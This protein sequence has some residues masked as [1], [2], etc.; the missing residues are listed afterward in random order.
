MMKRVAAG[1]VDGLNRGIG[2]PAT[3]VLNILSGVEQHIGDSRNGNREP[4][5]IPALG[6]C[7]PIKSLI[8]CAN[9]CLSTVAKAKAATGQSDLT[10][11]CRQRGEHPVGLLSVIASLQR[12]G[13]CQKRAPT[14]HFTSQG[15][16]IFSGYTTNR[17][18]PL[19]SLSDP[20][21]SSEQIVFYR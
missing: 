12:P 15:L 9:K 14:R 19:R 10:Q 21:G 8:V 6:E 20:I 13:C 18:R 7:C 4:R 16:N 2:N 1:P 3:I 11:H 17:R 5:R